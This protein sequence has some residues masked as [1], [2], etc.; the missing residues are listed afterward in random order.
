MDVKTEIDQ[1][2]C[3]SLTSTIVSMFK[4]GM[5]FDRVTVEVVNGLIVLAA[6]N[7]SQVGLSKKSFN[8]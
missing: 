7:F 2:H 3:N 8:T 1:T 5:K 6:W 4:N